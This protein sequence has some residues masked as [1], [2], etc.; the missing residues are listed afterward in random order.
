MT[1][2]NAAPEQALQVKVHRFLKERMPD[3][4]FYIAS[5]SGVKL[6]PMTRMKAKAA[7]GLRAGWPDWSFLCADG[8]TRFVELKRPDVKGQA[9]GAMSAEQ[10]A[11]QAQCAPFGIYAV[12]RSVDEV[13]AAL[14]GWG[15]RLKPNP[16][17]AETPA[18]RAW[19][20]EINHA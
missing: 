9:R 15:V 19:R 7:G 20:E 8:I 13:E 5:L 11:F 6:T 2:K 3:G 1:R 18:Q 10:K 12:C 16:F 4:S 14:I 17:A